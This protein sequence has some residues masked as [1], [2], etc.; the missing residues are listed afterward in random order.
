[1]NTSKL[2]AKHLREVHLGRNWTASNMKD[3]LADVSWR[4]ATTQIDSLNTIATLVFHSTY[5]MK[6]AI[7][8]L[9]GKPLVS[10]DELSFSHPP[11]NSAED[12]EAYLSTVWADTETLADLIENSPTELWETNFT[13][14][15]Y[16][17]YYRNI[18][19]IIEHTH[20]HLGQIALLKRL[21][22]KAPFTGG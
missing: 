8:V 2:I 15:R 13:E 9:Q 16:G 4:E 11:I 19:G 17:N 22:K 12:W 3:N 1:M 10:K 18:H 7:D 5:Y 14:K 21:I 20:Y 6:A